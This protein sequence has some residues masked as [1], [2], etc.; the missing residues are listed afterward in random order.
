MNKLFQYWRSQQNEK[1][2]EESRTM[3]FNLQ[4]KLDLALIIR[5]LTVTHS[6]TGDCGSEWL[7][8]TRG[9][10]V[11][12]NTG[13]YGSLRLTAT[14][15]AVAHLHTLSNGRRWLTMAQKKQWTV[16]IVARSN[17]GA[18]GSLCLSTGR[19]LVQSDTVTRGLWLTV[20]HNYTADCRYHVHS[21]LRGSLAYS[22]KGT[23]G[24]LWLN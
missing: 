19:G 2:R 5:P 6:D 17:T 11:N 7:T 24:S 8:V 16:K 1:Q 18:C 21:L 22:R 4:T 20:A 15:R 3:Q 12:T 13:G 23:C 9:T 14:Q 10:M